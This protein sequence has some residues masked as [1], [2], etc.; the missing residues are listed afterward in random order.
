MNVGPGVQNDETMIMVDS[1][2][3]VHV[4]PR[5]FAEQFAL[6]PHEEQVL[7]VDGGWATNCELWRSTC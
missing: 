3:V 2:S 4:C 7:G 5:D 1:G 6:T